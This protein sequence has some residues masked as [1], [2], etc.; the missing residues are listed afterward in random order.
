MI[1]DLII[2]VAFEGDI[3]SLVVDTDVP[4]RLEM[5]AV[6][7]QQ[8]GKFF[9][10]GSQTFSLPGSADNNRFFRNA[11]DVATDD[12]PGFYNTLPCSVVLNGETLLIGS[13]QLVQVVAS[14]DGYITYE[15][16]VVDKVLQFE[17]DLATK[18]I[19]NADWSAYNHTLTSQSV[20]DSWSGGLLAGAVYYPV[21]DYGR[22]QAEKEYFQA[23]IMQISSSAGYI[24]S[25]ATPMLLS[26]VLPAI[27]VKDT[28]DVIFDQVGFTYTG[29]FTETADFNNLYILNKPKEGLGV[30]VD[31]L[32]T[33]DFT[34]IATTNQTQGI[35]TN[36]VIVAPTE[37]LDP[38]NSYDTTTSTYT[39]PE[40]G[41]YTF[42][43]QVGFFNPVSPSSAAILL[44]YLH[45]VID[46]G[47]GNPNDGIVLNTATLLMDNTKGVGP[48]YLNV[49]YTDNF[50][51]GVKLRLQGYVEQFT[52][53]PA[54]NTTF[55]S[56][57][58]Q[59]RA[60]N[61]PIAYEGADII[62]ANQWQASTKSIDILKGLLTQ[63]NLVMVPQVDNKT[64]I[65][66]ETFD[67]WI[68]AG[69]IKDWT[70]KYD[71]AKRISI[72]HTVDELEKELFLQNV[73]DA[74]RF[75][76]LS[77]NSDP[78]EQYGTL[79][80][81]ADNNISQG[82]RQIESLFSPVILGGAVNFIAN[83]VSGSE[84]KPFNGSYDIDA[85]TSFVI[86]H[87]YK[88]ENSGQES[89]I[90][91]PRLG[92]KVTAPLNSGS[93]F[94]GNSGNNIE[95]S[96]SYTTISN[97]S[98]L[99][100]VS[101]SS[102]DLH[103][104]NTYT[105][106][107]TAYP[108]INNGVSAFTS[109][110]K[111]YLDSLYWEGSK[112][113]VMDLYFEP[114]EYKSI[115]LNDR[116][117]IK[118]Q[119]YRINK[120]SG[121][122]VSTR[123]VV[124][125]ELIKL[126]PAYWQ[127]NPGGIPVP[128]PTLLIMGRTTD[129]GP[130]FIGNST[131]NELINDQCGSCIGSENQEYYKVINIPMQNGDQLY[132]LDGLPN[133]IYTGNLPSQWTAEGTFITACSGSQITIPYIYELNNGVVYDVIALDVDCSV[134]TNQPAVTT[135]SPS[136]TT[137]TTLSVS[138]EITDI[139]VPDYTAKGFVWVNGVGT[140]TLASYD[141]INTTGFT[142]LGVFNYQITGL[143]P[144]QQ[145]SYRA[146]ATN[147]VGT[148]YG[149]VQTTITNLVGYYQL[150]NC[151][152][153][154]TNF[155][156]GQ[157]IEEITLGNSDRVTA[158]GVTYIVVGSTSNAG[159]PSVGTVVDTGLQ[160][161]PAT[162]R[163]YNYE[164]CDQ[165]G[166]TGVAYYP[167]GVLIANGSSFTFGGQ[168]WRILTETSGPNFNDFDLTGFVIYNSCLDCNTASE[169]PP[170]VS[171]NSPVTQTTTS[172]TMAGT[173]DNVGDPNYTVKGFVWVQGTGTPTMANNVETVSGTASGLYTKVVS[174]LSP[175]T[176]Y[177]YRAY[178]TNTV[179]TVYGANLTTITNL[180]G[181]YQLQDCSTLSTSHR[182]S[183][184]IEDITLGN[185][186][187]VTSG[188]VTYQVVG[189]TTNTGLPSY[190]VTDTGL[191]G[192]PATERFYNYEECDGGPVTGV[193]RWPFG[194]SLASGNSFFGGECF[195]IT[196]ETTTSG[197]D[198][199]LT[200]YTIYN[201]CTDCNNANPPT[202]PTPTPTP[203]P[204]SPTR[205]LLEDQS[206]FGGAFVTYDAA[207]SVGDL[208]TTTQSS[209]CYEI[210]SIQYSGTS[211]YTIEGPCPAPP[212]TPTPTP[213]PPSCNLNV[214]YA[215]LTYDEN[216]LCNGTT[217]NVYLDTSDLDTATIS[218]GLST[219]CSTV[220]TGTRYYA[221]PGAPNY[222][223]WNGSAM[224]GPF[225]LNC[226]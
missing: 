1:S 51:P 173:I 26:Q 112:K 25:P 6:E 210:M 170:S 172:I 119:A 32:T 88:F 103:F 218:Y 58:T 9:G 217:R 85:N 117:L 27:R 183:Q 66:I 209:L 42:Q 155:R 73:D 101:G 174:G 148:S 68:R 191:Q 141:G 140:P 72:N 37:T 113:V 135:Y 224:T 214:I 111:T 147:T 158:G 106:F 87:I 17:Q 145:L 192:C 67:T 46:P 216:E 176:Q 64:V 131:T 211:I 160:G 181:Y 221:K 109:Y 115:R 107:T 69:E 116:I 110:W 134:P 184:T 200:G 122:N 16:Q 11:Y 208:I 56:S 213:A 153:L 5:S 74:D 188:G 61:T 212:P 96:G 162:E 2:K 159:I 144:G 132:N 75:S 89:Y 193:A 123:D 149:N 78:N 95:V 76:Q 175:G 53:A 30:V 128:E 187:R 125:V 65:E 196:S 146:Y 3:F 226:P 35:L 204:V 13:L 44:V 105:P 108:D 19:K 104:N 164:E 54:L 126:Y 83:S 4:L 139:G 21:V 199:D 102:N 60:I 142:G 12:I 49:A 180:V 29:S 201:T 100:V 167:S 206:T 33:A 198:F 10:I 15:V 137:T 157:T 168:C 166:I 223:I 43:G 94:I 182:T 151:T 150:Q 189:S 186:D 24:G 207:Y 70:D 48:H 190:F 205:F 55:V 179:N 118:N 154:S 71:T 225:M 45:L 47:T 185:S 7:N 28:L 50:A 156:T 114:Y 136:A 31:N 91:K 22:T 79:R 120:I 178:A 194:S 124:T 52:G 161:C 63:F 215:S 152:T 38:T 14:E 220:Q 62:M 127:V 92:Y 20:V 165:G 93:F 90:S 36:F 129:I 171:T 80:L 81:L 99:P 219:T 177:T 130:A 8:V 97:V 203:T 163:Y 202:P 40:T 41:Q 197:L 23:P 59:F 57:Y 121:F 138:G 18:L 84:I 222:Y 77:I 39:V 143:T 133:T 86:P 34:A 169:F 82:T 98:S 195:R